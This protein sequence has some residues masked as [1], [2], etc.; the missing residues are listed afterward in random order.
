MRTR[1][2]Q[3]IYVCLLAAL[4]LMVLAGCGD[5]RT[6][7]AGEAATQNFPTPQGRVFTANQSANNVSVID[8]ATDRAF[9]T[10]VT[11]TGPH[12]VLGTPDGKEIW[13]TLYGENRLQIFDAQT[14][15]E[16]ASVDVGASNDDLT[17]DPSG[18]RLYISLGKDD[19]VAVVDVALRKSLSRIKVGKTPH[20][21][22]VTPDGKYLLVTNTADNTVSVLNLQK[23]PAV[24]EAAIKTGVNP[25]EV[26]VTDDSATAYVSNFLADS[27]SVVDLAQ[28][29]TIATIRSGKQP[30]M[31]ALQKGVS[32]Q[33]QQIWAANTGSAELWLIDMTTRKLVDRVPVGKGAHGVVPTTSGKL[34]VTNAEDNTVSVVDA[35]QQKVLTTIPVGNTPNGLCF[36][37]NAQ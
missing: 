22:K 32:G 1:H 31:I 15:K 24:A 20:G 6:E 3:S 14:L 35:A 2:R 23:E 10:I 30:A 28:H 4:A 37:P 16:L 36:L 8:V 11:G 13:V 27:L 19:S 5:A 17:F 29:K 18:K 21:V 12:H 26:V 9:A 34:Y 7:T 33:S 25:F